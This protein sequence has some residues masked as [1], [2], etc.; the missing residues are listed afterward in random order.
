M[1]SL[2]CP[3][4]NGMDTWFFGT[5]NNLNC[6]GSFVTPKTPFGSPKFEPMRQARTFNMAVCISNTLA[7]LQCDFWFPLPLSP[8]AAGK[9]HQYDCLGCLKQTWSQ[10]ASSRQLVPNTLIRGINQH[11]NLAQIGPLVSNCLRS[12]IWD[13]L[14]YLNARQLIMLAVKPVPLPEY[15]NHGSKHYTAPTLATQTPVTVHP[16]TNPVIVTEHQTV[17]TSTTQKPVI[18]QTSTTPV[19]FISPPERQ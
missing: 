10:M 7:S 8:E 19:V 15:L 17:T 16:S 2:E 3:E 11:Q 5:T 12:S 1:V 18:I 14:R 13:H 9:H 6:W 4:K